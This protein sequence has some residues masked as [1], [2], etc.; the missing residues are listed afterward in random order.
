MYQKQNNEAVEEP[1]RGLTQTGGNVSMP[2]TS[3]KEKWR[4]A[5]LVPAQ[6]AAGISTAG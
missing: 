2:S 6:G 4:E 3:L 5:K 1:Q